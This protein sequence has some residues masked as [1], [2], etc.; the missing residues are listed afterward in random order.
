MTG[1][2]IITEFNC[3]YTSND[4]KHRVLNLKNRYCSCFIVTICGSIRFTYEG[5][6]I[7]ADGEHPVFIPEGLSYRNECLESAVSL[8]FNFHAQGAPTVPTPLSRISHGFAAEKYREIEKALLQSTAE[9]KMTILSELYSL[10]SKLFAIRKTLSPADEAVKKATEYIRANYSQSTLTVSQVAREC[11]VSET[12]LR[13]LF[14]SKMNTTPSRYVTKI[15][16]DHAYH[17]A[18]ERLPVGE[19]AILVGY[20]DIYQFS[21]AYKKYFGCCPSETV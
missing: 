4:A 19:I 12:Y 8:V 18:R 17:L 5:G 16:M 15:R 11:F 6:S 9:N 13:K 2:F 10:A 21:R 7:V 1:N 14:A 3:I 20:A